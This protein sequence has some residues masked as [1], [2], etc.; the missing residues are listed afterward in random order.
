MFKEFI[1][2]FRYRSN[3]RDVVQKYHYYRNV[4]QG[5]NIYFLCNV[6]KKT[7]LILGIILLIVILFIGYYFIFNTSEKKVEKIIKN[8]ENIINECIKE[9]PETGTQNRILE[10]CVVG[11]EDNAATD[12]INR[13]SQEERLEFKEISGTTDPISE[14]RTCW[15][16]CRYGEEKAYY[17]DCILECF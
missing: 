11:C 7:Y 5:L 14:L 13:F 17:K 6:M 3:G 1:T 9:C 8:Y 10:G 2:S 16:N 15:E 4:R 12:L